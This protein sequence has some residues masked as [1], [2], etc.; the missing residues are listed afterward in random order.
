MILWSL[1]AIVTLLI[2]GGIA[3]QFAIWRNGPAVLSVIDKVAGGGTSAARLATVSTGDHPSQKAIVWGP[4]DRGPN[5]PALP[6]LIFAHGGSWRS[7]DPED[8]GFFARAFVP[9]G[10]IVVLVGYRLVDDAAPQTAT[11][12]TYPAMLEDTARTIH[13]ARREIAQYGGDPDRM[14]LAGHSAGA[15]NVV[16]TAL[17]TQWL[18]RY[19]VDADV[20]AGVVGMSGPYDFFPYDSPSTIAAFGNA[21]DPQATQVAT[22]VR[23]DGPPMLLIHG[24]KDD[25]VGIHNSRNLAREIQ[26]L[27]GD[28]TLKIYPAMAHND[29]LIALA[30]PWRSRRDVADTIASFAHGITDKATAQQTR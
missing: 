9:K 4:Q 19:G 26:G 1:G 22:H 3:L 8:Y 24:A 29:P 11:Q 27:G 25:L 16:M 20:I 18:G 13:W 28:V 2:I 10:F 12:G 15:Y 7:G 17:E 23:G 6:V 5:G 14:V 21:P 30:A